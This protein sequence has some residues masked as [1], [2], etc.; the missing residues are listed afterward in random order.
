[1]SYSHATTTNIATL[2][3]VSGLESLTCTAWLRCEAQAVNN[4]TN[5]LN[6]RFWGRPGQLRG[7]GAT[8]VRGVGFAKYSSAAAGLA[9]AWRMLKSLAP[10]YG[11]GAVLTAAAG[12]NPMAEAR[13][14]ELSSWAAG[15]YGGTTTRDGC[16][17]RYVR[18]H[19]PAPAPAPA[20]V[21]R[22]TVTL[23]VT[24]DKPLV[25][26]KTATLASVAGKNLT[27]Q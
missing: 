23:V 7:P 10:R 11:Y 22:E 24:G 2:R 8:G 18:A 25:V 6:V 26:T 17:R 4:P 21:V 19:L 1:M 14:I 3:R 12:R 20:P 5:P 13:A 27:V 15:H 9:D 16:L